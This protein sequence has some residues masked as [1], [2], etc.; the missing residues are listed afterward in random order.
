MSVIKPG[1]HGST[2]GGNPL[3]SAIAMTALKV[4]KEEGL[5]EN[6][7]KM[8]KRFRKQ[9][10]EIN[11]GFLKT[12]RG[13]GLLNAVVIDQG[14]SDKTAWHICYANSLSDLW[15]ISSKLLVFSNQQNGLLAKPTHDNIIRLAPP[16]CITEA[17]Q[18]ECV[19]IIE[20]SLKEAETVKVKDIPGWD[21]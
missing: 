17:Q 9:L 20:K 14:F 21:M 3:G 19:G 8:G 6:A 1:E 16:L 5:V 15:I 12:V 2:Y 4:L 10:G 11:S 18:D 13:K 7:E